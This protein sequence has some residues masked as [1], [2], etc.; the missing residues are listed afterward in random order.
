MRRRG[1]LRHAARAR[2]PRQDTTPRVVR[3]GNGGAGCG[4]TGDA[5][6]PEKF[7]LVPRERFVPA[8]KCF[9]GIFRLNNSMGINVFVCGVVGEL[10]IVQWHIRK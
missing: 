5:P 10:I 9:R 8:I 3:A 7:S 6:P 1:P 4:K 2:L